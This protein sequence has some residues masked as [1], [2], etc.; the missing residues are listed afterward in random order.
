MKTTKFIIVF[1]CICGSI[2]YAQSPSDEN[3]SFIDENNSFIDR[4]KSFI[5]DNN[6]FIDKDKSFIDDNNSFIDRNKSFIDKS[7]NFI[8]SDNNTIGSYTKS[9]DKNYSDVYES[10]T[11]SSYESS[12]EDSYANGYGRFLKIVADSGGNSE[13]KF[14]QYFSDWQ[15][16][17][18]EKDFFSYAESR[19]VQ[20]KQIAL[21]Y[22]KALSKFGAGTA[23]VATTWIVAIVVP[24]G[25]IYQVAILTIAKATT[26]GAFSG[27][28]VGAVS[29]CAIGYLQGKRGNELICDTV[30]GAADGYLIGAITGLASGSIKVAK[31]IKEAPNFINA[32]GET[33]TILNGK[34]YNSKG[35][36][37]G[38][39]LGEKH[40]INGFK[41]INDEM[42]GKKSPYGID[43]VQMLADDGNGNFFIVTNPDFS[44][45]KIVDKVYKAPRIK[46]G[47][48]SATIRWCELEYQK[49]L[50]SPNVEEILGISKKEA[51]MR[52]Q[53]EKGLNMRDSAFMKSNG[54]SENQISKF[55]KRYDTGAWHHLPESGELIYV[56]KNHY[57]IAPHTGGDSF[58]GEKA[59]NMSGDIKW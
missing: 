16:S 52:L 24:G 50:A 2:C 34:V 55:L 29:S 53:F 15:W 47:N 45:V 46:W 48:S 7:K 39:F 59:V 27:G 28:A 6:S 25:T 1:L 17:G 35:I 26:V 14:I 31:M 36:E 19:S 37:V 5:D 40:E 9:V 58:W 23:I 51:A 18:Q 54:L 13:Q 11:V 30:T 32:A 3:K 57:Q 20:E 21:C 44:S 41:I 4:D 56:P 43:Y 22:D 10:N 42:L 8:N 38:K 33:K 12:Y 49:D